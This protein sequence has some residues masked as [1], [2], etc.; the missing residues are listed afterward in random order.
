MANKTI[1]IT[2]NGMKVEVSFEGG[3]KDFHTTI[4][5]EKEYNK[6]VWYSWA[7]F[8]A[9]LD[10]RLGEVDVDEEYVDEELTETEE[11]KKAGNAISDYMRAKKEM[12]NNFRSKKEF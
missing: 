4:D 1:T 5:I 7:S 3:K 8:S 10:I 6:S 9:E 12:E 2:K 11:V